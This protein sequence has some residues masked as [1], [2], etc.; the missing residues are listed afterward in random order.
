[1]GKEEIIELM[2]S[3][4]ELMA[5][6]G[7]EGDYNEDNEGTMTLEEATSQIEGM[8]ITRKRIRHGVGLIG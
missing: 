4:G 5:N 1:M 8:D 2:D 7:I 6:A 3:I